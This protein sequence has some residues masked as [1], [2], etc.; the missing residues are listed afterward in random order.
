MGRECNNSETERS[1]KWCFSGRVCVCRRWPVKAGRWKS[2]KAFV[3]R[4]FHTL[5]GQNSHAKWP[6]WTLKT[7]CFFR[8]SWLFSPCRPYF[9]FPKPPLLARL[10]RAVTV[11]VTLSHAVTLIRTADIQSE[12]SV[13]VCVV[14]YVSCQGCGGMSSVHRCRSRKPFL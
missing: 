13:Q 2:R 10:R 9:T 3:L 11:S 4:L 8:P 5:T 1:L 12:E 7:K 6:M 14:K